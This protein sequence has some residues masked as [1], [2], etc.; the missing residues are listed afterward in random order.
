MMYDE[1][2]ETGTGYL[3]EMAT[4]LSVCPF[5]FSSFFQSTEILA[6]ST[7]IY[8]HCN[9]DQKGSSLRDADED[10]EG[11]YLASLL[12]YLFLLFLFTAH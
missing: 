4:N 12:S 5:T 7:A 10:F 11:T 2:S 6:F 9:H 1:N 3:M 8:M